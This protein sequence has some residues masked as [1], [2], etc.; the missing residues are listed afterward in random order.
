MPM[1]RGMN[2]RPDAGEVAMMAII[3]GEI[4]LVGIIIMIAGIW[5]AI[6]RGPDR[7]SGTEVWLW[8]CGMISGIGF[9]VLVMMAIIIGEIFLVGIIIM[10]AGIWL[11]IE[12]GPDRLSDTEVWLWLYGVISGIGLGALVAWRWC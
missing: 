5:L 2:D 3:I 6:E 1:L 7:V 11:A 8:L 9:G 10:I 12:R 4:F